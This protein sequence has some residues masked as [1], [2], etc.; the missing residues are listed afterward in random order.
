MRRVERI[1]AAALAVVGLVAATAHAQSTMTIKLSPKYLMT[2]STRVIEVV[3]VN[4]D[5]NKGQISITGGGP[6]VPISVC[7]SDAGYGN[8]RYRNVTNNG[9][10]TNSSLLH[11]GDEVSP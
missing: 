3:D 6:S 10:W 1:L 2:G 4:C 9:P 8:I 5:V 7:K 11:D